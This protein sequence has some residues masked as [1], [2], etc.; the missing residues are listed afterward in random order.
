MIFTRL[1]GSNMQALAAC[2]VAAIASGFVVVPDCASAQLVKSASPPMVLERV[3]LIEQTASEAKLRL[4][5]D[6][7]AN[8]YVPG[9]EA[10]KEVALNFPMTTCANSAVQPSSL[11]G[12]VRSI[13]FDQVDTGLTIHFATAK[14]A[15]YKVISVN[16]STV[17]LDIYDDDAAPGTPSP[18][19]QAPVSTADLLGQGY[20]LVRLEYADV[21][22]VVG[23]L[24]QGDSIKSND[25]FTPREPGFGSTSLTGGS[26]SQ[27]SPADTN[28]SDRPLGQFVDVSLAVDRRLNAVLLRGPADQIAKMKEEIA[29]FDVP[30][31]SVVLETELVE[32]STSGARDLGLDLTNGSGAIATG[33]L[34]TGGFAP[35]AGN[36]NP[37]G[38]VK[39]VNLQGA[40]YAQIQR[41]DAKIISRPRIAA[42]SG[43]TAKII[44]GNAIPILTSIALSGVNGVSQQ[45]Q[46]V[47]VGVTL[48]IA[49][50]VTDDGYV[51]SHIFCV[52][53][54]VSGYS[55]GY[56]T[57]SQ[58]EAEMTATV[59]DGETFVIGGLTQKTTIETN[60]NIPFLG[61]VPFL[62]NLFGT[63]HNS[64]E[65]TE[66]YI[67]VTSHII[68]KN[69]INNKL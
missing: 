64:K 60:S 24:T 46:Y 10:V 6:P 61:N 67:I 62:G 27:S 69:A 51:S 41:G 42:Q 5:F 68:R 1:H 18:S 53:S 19:A 11:N 43:S 7:H 63:N 3:N 25:S 48:Q 26:Y 29:T 36:L 31:D 66:L 55:Q 39:S 14:H 32:I 30:V 54:S 57:I 56:P 22:E 28:E 23:L 52:V 20:E 47:N 35:T 12:L 59:K 34:Q 40:L 49:P 4:I 50:R 38:W 8:G 13:K 17:E 2:A 58:R 45:V 9:P 37:T 44:T 16:D 33:T 15:K 21:S 65:D